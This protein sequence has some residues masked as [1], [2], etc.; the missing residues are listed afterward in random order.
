MTTD[1][2]IKIQ[3]AL[4]SVSDK[5]DLI[6]FAKAL[7]NRG[8]TIISTGGTAHALTEAGINV[9]SIED[10]TGFPE[11]MDGRIKTLHPLIHGGILARRDEDSHLEAMNAHNIQHID[12]VCVNLYPFEKTMRSKEATRREIIEK[13]D[14]GGPSMIRSAAK[15]FEFI[16]VVTSPEMYDRVINELDAHD[17]ATTLELR[18]ELATTAFS[19]IADYDATIA[20]WLQR[21]H[22]TVMPDQ[23][24]VNMMKVM[25]LRYGENPHQKACLYR[26]PASRGPT[27]VNADLLHGKPLSY[28]NLNDAA[29]ALALV[30]EFDMPAAAVIKHTNPC[31]AAVNDNLAVAFEQA[32]AGDPLAAYGGILAVNRNIDIETATQIVEGKKFFEV[33]V[34]VSYADDALKMLKDRWSTVRILAVGDHE[35]TP[36][37]KI[38][39]KSIPGGMIVQDQD[40]QKPNTK[41]WKH[42]AGP[43]PEKA[44]LKN[45]SILWSICKHLKSNAIA[46]GD[47]GQLYGAG[48]GQMDRVSACKIAVEKA[49]LEKANGAIA[50]SD[51]FFPFTDG[52]EILINAGIKMI[53]QPGGSKRDLDTLD[54]C[55]AKGVTCMLTGFRHFKH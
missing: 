18:S 24:R 15:N 47:N 44:Q 23:F 11:I 8:I 2:L 38:D 10:V 3:R 51:A 41:D 9:T 31:G 35:P 16:T 50:A 5:T 21:R 53:V 6:P 40:L 48:A 27:V 4:L 12:L 45:A 42:A 17:G 28:N 19:R 46:I 39:F 13:I 26:D 33:I 14:I 1:K 29:A 7:T 22:S 36:Y 49:G 20:S 55:N 37:R 54:L 25:E 32:Y 34:A 52:P 43:A 30:L